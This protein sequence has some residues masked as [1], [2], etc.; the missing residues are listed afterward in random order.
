VWIKNANYGLRFL[1]EL[2]ALAALAYWGSQTGPLAVSIVLAIAAPLAGAALW[3][4]FAAPKSGH[5][6][7]GARRLVVE[8]PFFGAATA[9]LAATGQWVLAAIFAVAVV[10]SELVTYGLAADDDG[11]LGAQ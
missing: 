9:G 7:P 3:G 1:L 10:L 8:V 11:Q 4:V 2:S 5:R 6:L